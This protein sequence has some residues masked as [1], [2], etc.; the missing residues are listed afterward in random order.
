M[1]VRE[2]ALEAEGSG[3]N[4]SK[5]LGW[6]RIG[7][8]EERRAREAGSP[9]LIW[10]TIQGWGRIQIGRCK[11]GNKGKLGAD[12]LFSPSTFSRGRPQPLLLSAA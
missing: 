9:T 7:E 12:A 8:V 10:E 1:K 11:L 3:R 2:E 6:K 4:G 5:V